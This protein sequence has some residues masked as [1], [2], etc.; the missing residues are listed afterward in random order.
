M[1]RLNTS[2]KRLAA[3]WVPEGY[4]VSLEYPSVNAVI[5][6]GQT[7]RGIL[8]LAY[9]GTASR[10]SWHLSFRS[11]QAFTD[12]A[13]QWLSNLEAWHARKV[14]DRAE[15]KVGHTLKVGNV[16]VSTWGYDQT[17]VDFYEVIAVRGKV[18]DLQEIGQHATAQRGPAGDLVIP[19]RGGRGKILKGKR[20]TPD[21]YIRINSYSHAHPWNGKQ[22]YQTDPM[23]GH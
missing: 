6:A 7:P 12:Y 5:H 22:M 16:L 3:R 13:A 19:I 8:A 1:Y 9:R 21:N 2:E 23:F 20:P 10:P 11:P 17:N 15:R 18:V 4:T 14:A